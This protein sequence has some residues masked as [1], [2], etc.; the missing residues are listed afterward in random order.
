MRRVSAIVVAVALGAQAAPAL[1][2]RFAEADRDGDG[3]ISLTEWRAAWEG[4]HAARDAD[5][6]G[7]L[8]RREFGRACAQVTARFTRLDSDRSRSIS[9]AEVTAWAGRRFEVLDKD[10]DGSIQRSEISDADLPEPCER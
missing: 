7:A 9:R 5:G 4:A 2:D 8:D 6:D 3:G 1:A 10:G